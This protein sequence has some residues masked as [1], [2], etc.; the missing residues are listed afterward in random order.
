MQLHENVI[1]DLLPL[2]RSG[3]ASHESRLLVEEYL[4]A[5]PELAQVAAL[6][7]SPDPGLEM[8]ALQR[9]RR[10]LY[11]SAWEKALAIFFT[12]LPLSFVVDDGHARFLFADYPGLIV[13]MAVTA[14]AFWTR[15]LWARRRARMLR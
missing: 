4:A 12:L 10:A 15:A 5:H 3:R 13:G 2:V 9:T 14:A 11:R 1:L 6:L 7:P 8:R